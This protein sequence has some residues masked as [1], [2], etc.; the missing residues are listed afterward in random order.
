MVMARRTAAHLPRRELISFREL[1]TRG[2]LLAR[3]A[4]ACSE[5][6]RRSPCGGGA[7]ELPREALPRP[8]R[9]DTQS[10]APVPLRRRIRR[11]LPLP[12]GRSPLRVSSLPDTRR[13][14]SMSR[15]PEKA[16]RRRSRP[17][18]GLLPWVVSSNVARAHSC[19]APPRAHP[20]RFANAPISSWVFP[21]VVGLTRRREAKRSKLPGV[22]N[23]R[24]HQVAFKTMVNRGGLEPPTR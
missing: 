4:A 24:D 3:S 1:H 21:Q 2:A 12:R 7:A 17:I 8:P 22:V 10:S 19:G 9:R 20:F 23:A 18:L 6:R 5:F 13:C 14:N 11:S 15:V 16:A